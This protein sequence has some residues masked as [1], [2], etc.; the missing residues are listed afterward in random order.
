MQKSNSGF[1][2]AA[3]VML[4]FASLFYSWKFILPEYQ[5]TQTEIS[6]ADGEIS[7]AKLKLDSLSTTKNNLDQL[8][9]LVNKLFIAV[10]EDKDTPNILTEFEAIGVKNK[11][12][13]PSI[14]I[15]DGGTGTNAG[16]TGAVAP[17]S[18]VVNPIS[19]SFSVNGSF[20]QLSQFLTAIEKDIR[21]SSVKSLS[22]ALGEEG[23]LSLS[24]QVEVY[25]RSAATVTDA[26]ASNLGLT[27]V[28]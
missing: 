19:V 12:S 21:F 6:Q 23:S 3:A 28:K 17:T 15:S 4:A 22:Y 24:V 1:Y 20:D 27:E 10:P 25:K 7:A 9:D 13:I 8:G 14:Q 16:A 5:K 26:G 18:S 2:A 11:L